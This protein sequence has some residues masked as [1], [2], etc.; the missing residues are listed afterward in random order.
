MNDSDMAISLIKEYADTH[1]KKPSSMEKY[2]LEKQS[3]SQWAIY[4]II[5]R[6]M[7]HPKEF[8]IYIV[9]DYLFEMATYAHR[10][11]NEHQ[12]FI[13][14]TAVEMAEKVLEMLIQFFD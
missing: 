7:D 14:Y 13:F 1:Y 9:E 4:E 10:G 6:I 5:N 11:E 8:P 2:E 12:C 3:Y